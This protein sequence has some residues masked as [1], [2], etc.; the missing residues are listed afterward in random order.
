MGDRSKEKSGIKGGTD[1]DMR[2]ADPLRQPRNGM[3]QPYFQRGPRA[4]SALLPAIT[5]PV[6]RKSAPGLATL[7]SEWTTIAGPVL[8]S[9]ATPRKL[10]K[11]TLVLGCT[12]PAAM[13]LQHST[14]QLIQRIN[15]FLG[16]K[17]V[18]RIRLTQEAPPAPPTVRK[19]PVRAETPAIRAAVER[20]LD[21][22]PEGGLRDALAA[23]GTAML[24][25]R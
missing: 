11:G 17:A 18:E 13:E 22:L 5:R 9:T 21:G 10:T 20:R 4:I 16:N 25:K 23:L 1:A 15:F 19:K 8:S 24:S 14:P 6:F 3:A 12:G 7:L 2:Q